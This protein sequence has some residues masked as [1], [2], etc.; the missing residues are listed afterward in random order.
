MAL[1]ND[2]LQ[3]SRR[4]GIDPYNDPF[5]PSELRLN[6]SKYGSFSDYCADTESSKW[7]SNVILRPVELR[8][9]GKPLRY[10]LIK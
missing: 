8:K 3:A 7:N 2:I 5:K 1:K 9:D 6:A 4:I 10:L